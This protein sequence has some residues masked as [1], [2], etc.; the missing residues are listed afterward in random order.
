MAGWG[1]GHKEVLSLKAVPCSPPQCLCLSPRILLRPGPLFEN[2]PLLPTQ[3]CSLPL[4]SGRTQCLW[5]KGATYKHPIP[6]PTPSMS[7]L[8]CSLQRDEL[9]SGWSHFIRTLFWDPGSH[10]VRAVK[11]SQ[12]VSC[13]PMTFTFL[14]NPCL[15]VTRDSPVKE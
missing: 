10:D 1:C 8:P 4:S 15:H 3:R 11:I 7:V 12:S 5:R 2:H 14:S 13:P 6:P 9:R